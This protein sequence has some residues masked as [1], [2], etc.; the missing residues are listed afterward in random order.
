M[1]ETTS[2]KCFCGGTAYMRVDHTCTM[3]MTDTKKSGYKHEIRWRAHC[4]KCNLY[5]GMTVTEYT[6]SELPRL[7]RDRWAETGREMWQE[8]LDRRLN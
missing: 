8:Y 6:D 3:S 5:L 2:I 4:R 1:I 7:H